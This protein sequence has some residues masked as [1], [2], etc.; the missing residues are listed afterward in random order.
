MEGL[1]HIFVR[2]KFM[3]KKVHTNRSNAV[4]V[5][6]DLIGLVGALALRVSFERYQLRWMTQPQG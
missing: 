1:Q 4:D 6:I 3:D 2:D 5:R